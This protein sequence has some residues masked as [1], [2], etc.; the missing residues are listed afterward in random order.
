LLENIY[1][2]NVSCIRACAVRNGAESSFSRKKIWKCTLRKPD[3]LQPCYRRLLLPAIHTSDT[4]FSVNTA[5][6][7]LL[8]S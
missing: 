3:A 2:R 4:C 1:H 5:W 6:G 8:P 7:D